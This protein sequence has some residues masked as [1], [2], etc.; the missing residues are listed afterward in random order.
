MKTQM[1][2]QRIKMVAMMVINFVSFVVASAG[3]GFS[4]VVSV[5]PVSLACTKIL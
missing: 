2:R 5:V 1:K 4:H 3:V